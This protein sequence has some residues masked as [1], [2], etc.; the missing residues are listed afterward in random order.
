MT[1][2][3]TEFLIDVLHITLELLSGPID[4][5]S[6]KWAYYQLSNQPVINYSLY[7]VNVEL[8]TWNNL[9]G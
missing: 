1:D 5:E 6:I 4:T 2:L 8:N 9:L 7:C 3:F